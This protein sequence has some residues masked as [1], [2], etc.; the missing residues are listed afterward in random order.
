MSDARGNNSGPPTGNRGANGKAKVVAAPLPLCHRAFE[1]HGLVRTKV[2]RIKIAH[3]IET[4]SLGGVEQTR[5]TLVKGLDPS[6]Y[7]H[8][9]ICTQAA[10]ALPEKFRELGCRVEE[11]GVFRSAIDRASIRNARRFMADF[12]PDIVHGSVFEGVVTAVVAGRLEGV[13]I[14]VGEEASDP[15]GRRLGGHLLF[16]ALAAFTDKMVAVSPHAQSYLRA[17]LR[18]PEDKVVLVNNGVIETD[19]SSSPEIQATRDQL[20]LSEADFVIGTVGRLH[21]GKCID[22][23]VKALPEILRSVPNARLM[24]VGDGPELERLR[25]LSIDL[26]VEERVVFAGYQAQTRPF[27]EVMNVFL[28]PTAFEAFGLV[29]V[30]AMFAGLP[31]VATRVGGIPTVVADGETGILVSPGDPEAIAQQIIFLASDREQRER[32]GERGRA[33]A[34]SKF[35]QERYVAEIEKMYADL[36]RKKLG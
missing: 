27:Y 14:I 13:P 21:P 33:R 28:H 7:E 29:L 30:E 20:G 10:G 25:G 5:Y 12:R 16:R 31:V 6:R 8:M 36:V 34:R 19:A 22:N 11:I 32:M 2:K 9:V 23:A 26:H 18:I 4:M 17:K 35:G 15:F 3:C 1:F 24:V